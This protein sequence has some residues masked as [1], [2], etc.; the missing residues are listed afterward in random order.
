MNVR[1]FICATLASLLILS[2]FCCQAFVSHPSLQRLVASSGLNTSSQDDQERQPWDFFRFVRQSSSFIDILPRQ[3]QKRTVQPGDVLWNP[4]D[5]NKDFDF[6][7]LDDV[8]MGGASSSTFDGSTGKWKGDVT[9]ANSGGFIGIRSTPVIDLDMS[10]CQGIEWRLKSDASLRFKFVVRD[11][12]DFN[13]ITW[14]T[15]KDVT[16][17]GLK[18]PFNKQIP[19]RFAKTVDDSDNFKSDSLKSFQLVFS[20]FEYDGALN[21]KFSTGKFDVQIEDIRA[22]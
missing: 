15:S 21:P 9:D 11:S 10:K 20:K 14:T 17:G 5:T 6:S 19:T 13:G 22:Y 16:K 12:T 1:M 2:A 18:I 7:P 4:V 8:V 3:I